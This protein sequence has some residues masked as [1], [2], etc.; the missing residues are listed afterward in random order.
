MSEKLAYSVENAKKKQNGSV[1]LLNS[2]EVPARKVE[3]N[4]IEV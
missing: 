1:F 3:K 4:D 2:S